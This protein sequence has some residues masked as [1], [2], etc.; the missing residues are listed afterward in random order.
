MDSRNIVGFR[1]LSGNKNKKTDES[2][3]TPQLHLIHSSNSL[4]EQNLGKPLKKARS[5]HEKY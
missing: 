4:K 3:P 1:G 2:P 5:V